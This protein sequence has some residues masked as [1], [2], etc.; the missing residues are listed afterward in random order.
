[1]EP[2]HVFCEPNPQWLGSRQSAA[3]VTTDL[4]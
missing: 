3:A 2:M 4:S 1:M